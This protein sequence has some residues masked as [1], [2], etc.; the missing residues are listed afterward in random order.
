MLKDQI[1]KDYISAFKAKNRLAMDTLGMLKSAIQYVEVEAKAKGIEL[2][3]QDLI[4]IIQAE[5]KKRKEAI[6]SFTKA[7]RLESVEEEKKQL[8]ILSA[9]LP[10][11]MNQD[12]IKAIILTAIASVSASGMDDFGKVMK[13]VSQELKGKADGGLIKTMVEELLKK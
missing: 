1:Q 9:Y 2:N 10:E 4:K 13:L 8:D 7:G 11:P 6:D 3:E 12:D 5:A